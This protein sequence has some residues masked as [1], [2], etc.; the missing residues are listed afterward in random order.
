MSQIK[1]VMP[2]S[3]PSLKC[4]EC[5]ERE[6]SIIKWCLC[7]SCYD[8][9]RKKGKLNVKHP[10]KIKYNKIE[11]AR[12]RYPDIE[13]M[14]EKFKKN[15]YLSLEDIGRKY[16]ISREY[17][18]QVFMKFL[19]TD[20]YNKL[21]DFRKR[22]KQRIKHE[23]QC[24]ERNP[25]VKQFLLTREL[26]RK[27]LKG[28]IKVVEKCFELGYD[29]GISKEGLRYMLNI[30]GNK[31]WVRT[32]TSP[33]YPNGAKLYHFCVDIRKEFDVM[34]AYIHPQDRFYLFSKEDILRFKREKR[35]NGNQMS[36]YLPSYDGTRTW[37]ASGNKITRVD[38]YLKYRDN[39]T[40]LENK[41]HNEPMCKITRIP[42]ESIR[43]VL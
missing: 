25:Y 32:A 36:I 39:W 18:R 24:E 37:I 2:I 40:L 17:V 3:D 41:K 5:R 43:Q 10:T 23:M 33:S 14:L 11:F 26:R 9:L 30:N 13:K 35:T 34:V 19:G 29:I 20:N 42:H 7:K 16:K 6:V 15:P 8:K 1:I 12:K 38:K 28:V 21:I 22:L 31:V 27:S 4:V